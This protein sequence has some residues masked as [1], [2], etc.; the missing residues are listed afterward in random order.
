M[1]HMQRRQFL[2]KSIGTAV[3]LGTLANPGAQNGFAASNEQLA[4][5]VIGFNGMGFGHVRSIAKNSGARLVTLCDVDDAVLERGKQ[6]VK[7]IAGN[8]PKL[9][10]DFR[11]VL[12]DPSID[13][14]TIATPNHWHCPIAIRALQAGKDVYVE[15]P[16][17]HV[18]QEGRMLVDAARKYNRIVQHGTQM[19]SS[20]VTDEA[21]KVLK[22]GILGDIKITKAWNVQ[23]RGI[24]K[25]VPDGQPPAGVDYDR[26]LGPAPKRSFNVNRFH[27]NW[28][29]FRDYSNG[30][31]GDDGAHDLDM[32][33]FGLGVNEHPVQITAHGSNVRTPGYREFPDNMTI[34]YKYAD[35][36]VLLYEDRMFTPYG[37]H[38]VDS[39]NA[40][41][42]TEGYMIF[43]R[44]GF[45]R[46]FL[47]RKEEKGPASGKSGRVGAPVPTH[48]ENYLSCVRSRKQPKAPADVAH[49]V[50]ALIHLGEIAYRTRSVLEF[51]PKTER[52]VNNS[53]LN[54]LLT[55]EYRAPYG[56]PD[57]V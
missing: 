18:F 10:R 28:R 42:G 9:V 46:T 7:S 38:G 45:F 1:T 51:D 34:A 49:R 40:F 13:A 41:Y 3:A 35:E 33:V 22:S 30:D 39:G 15:K 11:R 17:S 31:F 23:D 27:R 14:V 53:K 50:C 24:R 6:A 19:R 12:D 25:P 44:R 16:A 2:S 36:R 20:A 26:W 4:I 5:A 21:A 32:A 56:M 55:K 47:G 48:V 43:S 8:T 52:I 54:D 37:L 57:K 29:F